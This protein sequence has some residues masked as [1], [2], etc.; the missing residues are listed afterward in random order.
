MRP[1]SPEE[2]LPL[3][4]RIKTFLAQPNNPLIERAKKL[5]L[6]LK[7]GEHIPSTRR[8]HACTEYAR[9]KGALLAFHHEVLER[10]WSKGEDLHAWSVLRAAAVAAQIDA[11]EMER[12]VTAG[13]WNAEV[14]SRL[15][16]ASDIGINAVPTSV[17]NEKYFISGAQEAQAF[18]QLFEK[19]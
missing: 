6:T 13:R 8:A 3:P 1:D 7:F 12:E 18:R 19:L 2:G 14:Q 5:G 9:S 16:Q 4:E 17:V 11:D 10:Y 15:Q